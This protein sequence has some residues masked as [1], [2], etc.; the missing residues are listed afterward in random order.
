MLFPTKSTFYWFLQHLTCT[1][2]LWFN[3]I[4]QFK[5]NSRKFCEE[6][7]SYS[8]LNTVTSDSYTCKI[9]AWDY[10]NFYDNSLLCRQ[11]I[12]V[13]WHLNW[14]SYKIWQFGNYDTMYIGA[15]D[16]LKNLALFPSETFWQKEY[17]I[18]QKPIVYKNIYV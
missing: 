5:S 9:L 7:R 18:K 15:L 11:K 6:K 12:H 1:G 16:V 13:F 4:L 14:P 17:P 8:D 3:L 2:Y 10:Q